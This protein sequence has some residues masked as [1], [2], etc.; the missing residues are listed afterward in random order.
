MMAFGANKFENLDKGGA[1]MLRAKKEMG[2]LFLTPVGL[3]LT[4]ALFVAS[5]DDG[6]KGQGGVSFSRDVLPLFTQNDVWY[7]GSLSCNAVGCHTGI[8]GA[9]DLDMGSYDGILLGAD[10]GEEPIV[11][12]FDAEESPLRQ[13]LRNN[14]MPWNI[15]TSV[16]RDG[17]NGEVLIVE[18][19]I[20][21]GAPDGDFMDRDDI[22]RN[23]DDDV[24]PLFTEPDV[25]FPGSLS[26]DSAGCHT[27]I[28]GAH[29]LDMGSYDGILLG[30][31]AGEEPIVIPFDAEE[32]PL[33]QRLRNNRMPWN[34][35]T[36]VP[37]D[38][39][40]GEVLIVEE[41][42]DAGAPDN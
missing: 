36:S 33:R 27:G 39:P 22:T 7:P 42:I 5:C 40:N 29:D 20:D 31:D 21:A 8:G 19:W 26:C 17:P 32:S 25:W 13:R 16:P 23:F 24:L 1:D 4:L 18:D 10:A 14:R 41:W 3:F 30:A 37:R 11:I 35:S 15:P 12:P 9:H 2:C 6:H 34:I 38:G 28:G